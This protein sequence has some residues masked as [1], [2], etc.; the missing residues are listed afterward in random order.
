M[1]P[2]LLDE[3]HSFKLLSVRAKLGKPLVHTT[4]S[5]VITFVEKDGIAGFIG[6]T[7][8]VMLLWP[9][10]I[11]Q[12]LP[13]WLCIQRSLDHSTSSKTPAKNLVPNL[14]ILKDV[15][16]NNQNLP[17]LPGNEGVRIN[18]IIPMPRFS[19]PLQYQAV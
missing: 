7:I 10:F 5:P 1:C 14:K 16:F 3:Y 6:Q 9:G 17:R 4:P 11:G 12:R 15:L 2:F 19:F 8:W 13:G 18:G